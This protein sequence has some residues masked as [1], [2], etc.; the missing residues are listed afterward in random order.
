MLIIFGIIIGLLLKNKKETFLHKNY[1]L[2]NLCAI[3]SYI[4]YLIW[5]I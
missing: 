2:K 4:D 5:L 1:I 3:L